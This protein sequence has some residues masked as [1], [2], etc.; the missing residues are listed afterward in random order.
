MA[1]SNQT[2][3]VNDQS[4]SPKDTPDGNSSKKSANKISVNEIELYSIIFIN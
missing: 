3:P 1:E 4:T 2:N